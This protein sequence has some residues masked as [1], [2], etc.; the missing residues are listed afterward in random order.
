[1]AD[2]IKISEMVETETLNE[3]DLLSVVS[4]GINKKIKYKH[5][6]SSNKYMLGEQIIGTWIDGRPIYRNIFSNY[7]NPNDF[8]KLRTSRD[9]E[10]F[11]S[12]YYAKIDDSINWL[13]V[14]FMSNYGLYID[15]SHFKRHEDFDKQEDRIYSLYVWT[16]WKPSVS[17]TYITNIEYVKSEVNE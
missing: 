11:D 2:G 4:E 12:G 17:G 3:D 7:L 15:D 13:N 10:S 14:E 9:S 8:K 1:M 16:S 5:F 6:A